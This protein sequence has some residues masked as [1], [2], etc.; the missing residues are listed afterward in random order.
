MVI[1]YYHL[2]RYGVQHRRRTIEKIAS[3][4]N[5][6]KLPEK[7]FQGRTPLGVSATTRIPRTPLM[8]QSSM[9]FRRLFLFARLNKPADTKELRTKPAKLCVILCV[10]SATR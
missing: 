5:P 8:M 2:Y 7:K 10:N 9:M 3:V 1:S 6:Q 4:D